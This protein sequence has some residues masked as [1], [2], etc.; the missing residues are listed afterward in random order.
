MSSISAEATPQPAGQREHSEARRDVLRR[1]RERL[2]RLDALVEDL[3]IRMPHVPIEAG[4]VAHLGSEELELLRSALDDPVFAD[5]DGATV[6][7]AAAVRERDA[8]LDLARHLGAAA[9]GPPARGGPTAA[10]N[11]ATTSVLREPVPPF[12]GQALCAAAGTSSHSSR[13]ARA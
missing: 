1:V 4:M 2:P 6:A 11:A 7:L 10:E 8:L 12:A 9:G 13:A 5:P 3:R